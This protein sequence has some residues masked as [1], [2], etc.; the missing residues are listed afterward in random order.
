MSRDESHHLLQEGFPGLGGK[1]GGELRQ[2]LWKESPDP[3]QGKSQGP[4]SHRALGAEPV[5]Q[6]EKLSVKVVWRF[7]N[8]DRP[9]WSEL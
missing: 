2:C 6:E 4:F 3:T 1:E 5:S 8:L 9:G 7:G